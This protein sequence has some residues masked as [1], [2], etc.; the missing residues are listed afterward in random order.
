MSNSNALKLILV[1]D[2]ILDEPEPDTFFEPARST[3]LEADLLVGHVEVPHTRCG[4]VTT[5][6]VPAPPSNPDNLAALNRI[7]ITR[8]T[9]FIPRQEMQ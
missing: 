2:L 9:H 1:G 5:F 3:L 4:R 7:P 6:E 8:H